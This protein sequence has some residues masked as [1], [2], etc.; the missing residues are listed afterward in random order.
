MDS[1]KKI[2]SVI[3]PLYNPSISH[4]IQSLEKLVETNNPFIKE[5]VLV[6][7][8]SKKP[9][10]D[11]S[12]LF[13]RISLK[14]KVIRQK[15]KGAGEARNAGVRI[16]KS[17]IVAFLD[18][19]C[20]PCPFWLKNIIDPII[21]NQAVAVGGK[22]LTFKENNI[23]SKFSDFRKALREP[24]KNGE[25]EIIILITA[26][27]AFS[28]NVFE[29]VGGFD[30]KF[31]KAGGE[32]LDLTYRLSQAGYS[33]KLLY[34][35]DAIVEHKHR[36]NLAKFLKQQFNYGFGDMLHF[37]YRKRNPQILGVYYPTPINVIRQIKEIIHFSINLMPTIPRRYGALTKYLLFPGIAFIRRTAVMLGGIS[38]YYFYAPKILDSLKKADQKS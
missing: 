38:C 9:V 15:N 18:W 17:S 29:S 31:K 4:L 24:I 3:Y 21:S 7:D 2:A 1:N 12:Q 36:T 30:P 20:L 11:F 28:K 32:D 25:G 37:L 34:Q 14:I 5:I 22:I 35:P 13:K 10:K 6:D 27:V 23:L 33:A 8:G 26:N 19:D 16:A